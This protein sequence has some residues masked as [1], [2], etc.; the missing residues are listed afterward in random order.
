MATPTAHGAK[1]LAAA[2]LLRAFLADDRDTGILII[3]QNGGRDAQNAGELTRLL[4][5]VTKLAARSLLS[6]NGYDPGRTMKVI[7]AWLARLAAGEE[8]PGPPDPS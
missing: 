7:D 3:E 5:S 4:I 2:S 1:D 6:A 8:P